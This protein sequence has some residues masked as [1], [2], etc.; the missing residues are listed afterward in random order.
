MS[1]YTDEPLIKIVGIEA[2]GHGHACEA[3][4]VCGAALQL[5]TAVRFRTVQIVNG[6]FFVSAFVFI[7]FFHFCFRQFFMSHHLFFSLLSIMQMMASKKQ[8]SE[9]TG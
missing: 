2:S 3:H 5:N 8:P 9:F 1:H 4:K 7:D 6:E